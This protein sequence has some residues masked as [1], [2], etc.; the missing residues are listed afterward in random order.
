MLVTSVAG[1][2]VNRALAAAAR[3]AGVAA[4]FVKVPRRAGGV[5]VGYVEPWRLGVDRFVA[6]VGAHSLFPGVAVLRGGGGDCDDPRSPRRGRPSS[7]RRDHSGA[8]TH[9]RYAADRL[10]AFAAARAA[11]RAARPGSSRAPPAQASSR[12]RA[13]RPRRSSI[14]RWRRPC[15][16]RATALV[17]LHG[18]ESP[19][20]RPL[21]QSACV[22]VA[23]LVL[24]GLAVLAQ[25][26]SL[27][28]RR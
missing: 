5:T 24:R 22:G 12:D 15:P 4:E 17:V 28:R 18:G 26:G 6:A 2:R 7:G 27:R 16:R 23:D 13:T 10:T 1:T 8:G 19:L 3:R 25:P 9:G 20:V 14:A 11:E 21:V